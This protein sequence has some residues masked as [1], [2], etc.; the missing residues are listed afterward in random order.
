MCNNG[1]DVYLVEAQRAIGHACTRVEYDCTASQGPHKHFRH[2]KVNYL[3][4]LNW[5]TLATHERVKLVRLHCEPMATQ[6]L[7]EPK[8]KH[9][10]SLALR[11]AGHTSERVK[12][13]RLLSEPTAT[14]AQ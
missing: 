12:L 3:I 13:V 1:T 10:D 4:L 8:T 11:A 2:P 7:Q 14:P 6:A 5:E 9:F